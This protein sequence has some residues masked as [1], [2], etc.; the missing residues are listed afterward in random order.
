MVRGWIPCLTAE[1]PLAGS[2]LVL[3][4]ASPT[5]SAAASAAA[6]APAAAAAPPGLLGRE[7]LGGRGHGRLLVSAQGVAGVVGAGLVVVLGGG[8]V[9][10]G[11]GVVGRG[12]LGLRGA[13]LGLVGGPGQG[14]PLGGDL[15]VEA[16][17]V[18]GGGAVEVEPPVA[19]EVVLVEESSVGA[20]EA[21]LGEAAS[22]VGGADVESLALG[23][24]V[25]VVT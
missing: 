1:T 10:G 9:S 25:R 11:R 6:P 24:G 13:V 18:L 2:P 8:V 14:V 5:T 7:V 21:V 16:V 12:V 3:P 15:V 19:D 17:E 23:L 4:P 22:S 20:E